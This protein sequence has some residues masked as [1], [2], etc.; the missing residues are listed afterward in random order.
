MKKLFYI[1]ILFYTTQSTF[2]FGQVQFETELSKN[3]LGL[4][5]RLRV[6]FKMNKNGDNFQPPSFNGFTLVGGPNQSVSNSYVNGVRSF[7]KSYSYFLTPNRKGSIEIGQA[8]IEIDGE[9]YKTS[10][11]RVEVTEAVSKPNSPESKANAIVDQNL[12][13]VAEISNQRP[14]LNQSVNIIYKL[15]FSSE[16]SISNVNEVEMPKYSDFWSTLLPIPKLEIK[17]GEYKGQPYNYVVWRKAVL[18]PQKTGKLS[19]EPL[20][21]NVSVDVPTN[22]RDFFGNRVYQKTPKVVTAGKRILNVKELPIDNK[23]KNFTGAVGQFDFSVDFNKNKLKSSESFQATLKVSGNGNLKL[24]SL[25]KLTAPSSLEIYDPEHKENVKTNLSGMRGSIE[26]IYT[27]V[28]QLKGNYPVPSINFSFFDPIK[29]RYVTLKS[30]ETLINVNEGPTDLIS[31][32]QTSNSRNSISKSSESY[33]N[34]IKTKTDLKKINSKLFFN[35]NLFWILLTLPILILISVILIKRKIENKVINPLDERK[36]K[37]NFLAKKY[38]SEAKKL[39]G[40]K[41]EFYSSLEKALHNY[42][43]S[44][45]N[46]ETTDLSKDVISN[47]LHE[48]KCDISSIESFISMLKKCEEARYSPISHENMGQHYEK[49]I[50]TITIIDKQI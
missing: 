38:F 41:E 13:L 5:E 32:N 43:K 27:V 50:E 22:R 6:T 39:I 20:T 7:S 33:F 9:V 10:P 47:L 17:R 25:P 14:Y 8:S 30:D 23:P 16:I 3:R 2:I 28:P 49:A 18:Y 21:L 24:F 44:K 48:N 1:L 40:Q 15:Y 19:I 11:K 46:V 34:F 36:K 45:L 35:S 31:E 37:A 12:H 4:N 42:M 26:D 29:E